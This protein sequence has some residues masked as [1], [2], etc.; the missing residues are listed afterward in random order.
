MKRIVCEF[1]GEKEMIF[2][3][4]ARLMQ[5][6]KALGGKITTL[7]SQPMGLSEVITAYEIGLSHEGKK[8]QRN[9][10]W[11]AEKIDELFEEGVTF[12]ELLLPVMKAL[13]GS[14]IMGPKAYAI[15]FPDEVTEQEKAE[16]DA[17][18]E[19]EKN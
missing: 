19:A 1:F 17:Q 11:Y 13:I 3:N 2:F 18:E 5:L 6:E 10:L 4:V 7:L 8:K 16:L 15:A 9:Q 12:D 14:G